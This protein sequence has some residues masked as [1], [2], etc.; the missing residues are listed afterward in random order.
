[1]ASGSTGGPKR[2]PVTPDEHADVT[3]PFDLSQVS[4]LF[5]SLLPTGSFQVFADGVSFGQAEAL[6]AGAGISSPMFNIPV[7][8]FG[9]QFNNQFQY[10]YG[11]QIIR[12]HGSTSNV[13]VHSVNWT[14]PF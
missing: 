1:M 2:P 3:I 13:Q 10:N 12:S 5:P 11:Y 8:I 6:G 9:L 7:N 14:L 4:P